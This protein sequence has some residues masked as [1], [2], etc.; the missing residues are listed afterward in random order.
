[1]PTVLL[2]NTRQVKLNL[3]NDNIAQVMHT[4]PSPQ[5]NSA[6]KRE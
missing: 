1:M 6:Y 3:R 4:A 5:N 2:K